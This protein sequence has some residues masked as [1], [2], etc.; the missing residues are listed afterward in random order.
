MVSLTKKPALP[1][2]LPI[3]RINSLM[4]CAREAGLIGNAKDTR[5][6]GRLPA[7]LVEAAKARTGAQTDTELLEIAL[8]RV[9]LEDDFGAKLVQR[10]GSLPEGIDIE[11]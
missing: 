1:Q 7:R 3:E 6:S 4:E 5:L 10:K 8:A 9:A 11:F 2:L